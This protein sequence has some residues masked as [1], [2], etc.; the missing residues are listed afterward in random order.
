MD[1]TAHFTIAIVTTISILIYLGLISDLIGY[2]RAFHETTWMQ[3]GQPSMWASRGWLR[4]SW[5]WLK[6]TGFLFFS[7]R[8]AKLK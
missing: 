6:L 7:N 4:D 8:Y 2:L 3:L 1:E 5:S